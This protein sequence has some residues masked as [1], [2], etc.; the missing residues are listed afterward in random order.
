MNT[1][2]NKESHAEQQAR[3]QLASVVE[4]LRALECDYDRLEELRDARFAAR[5]IRW[6]LPGYM[7]DMTPFYVTDAEAGR[8]AIAAELRT[9]AA[10]FDADADHTAMASEAADMRAVSAALCDAAD[11]LEASDAEEYGAI[12]AGL[13]YYMGKAERPADDADAEELRELEE[14][15]GEFARLARLNFA[16]IAACGFPLS[17]FALAAC[18][19]FATGV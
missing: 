14:A 5:I 3:A 1:E 11:A 6:N 17:L 12:H 16:A 4:L 13:Y 18:F 10:D 19:H 8:A 2:T 9:R 7:P 15:A